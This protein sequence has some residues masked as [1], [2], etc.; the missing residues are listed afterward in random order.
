M[1]SQSFRLRVGRL[2]TTARDLSEEARVSLDVGLA[3]VRAGLCYQCGDAIEP[4]L[5]ELGSPR[6]LNCGDTNGQGKGLR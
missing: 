1:W 3:R 5:L 6:C 2:A 4:A